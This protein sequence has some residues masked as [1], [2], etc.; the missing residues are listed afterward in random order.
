MS[1]F[2]GLNF[3]VI[4]AKSQRAIELITLKDGRPTNIFCFSRGAALELV[5]NFLGV[6]SSLDKEMGT[7]E[8]NGLVV[9]LP[10]AEE[11]L[12]KAKKEWEIPK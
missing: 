6:I 4:P 12:R 11:L 8:W 10:D 9:P 3:K 1:A 5:R 7:E 2:P